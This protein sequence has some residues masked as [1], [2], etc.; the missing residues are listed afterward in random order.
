MPRSY[1][2]SLFLTEGQAGLDYEKLEH[3]GDALL[4][5][6]AV[7][8]AHELFPNFRQGSAAIMRDKLVS[9]STLAQIARQY[10]M[11][12]RIRCA[13]DAR[14]ALKKNEKVA[15]SVFEAY[16]AGVYY[17]YLQSTEE[18][19]P[20]SPTDS[21]NTFESSSRTSVDFIGGDKM[22]NPC[23]E[24]E[25]ISSDEEY[26]DAEIYSPTNT[27]SDD[28]ADF[29]EDDDFATSLNLLFGDSSSDDEVEKPENVLD[30][31]ARSSV[32][33][34]TSNQADRG[35]SNSFLPTDPSFRTTRTHPR[36]TRAQAYDYLYEW[37]E[38]V[39][40][41]IAHF[42]LAH[43]KVEDMRIKKEHGKSDEE[44]FIIPLHWKEEDIK[45][46]GGKAI[47][48]THFFELESPVYT[49]SSSNE[50][51]PPTQL[52]TIHCRV[53]DKEGT[54]WT[55][56]GTRTTKQAASNLAAWKIC[57]AMGLIKETD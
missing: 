9:N 24:G 44:P 57:V 22:N 12:D 15:A 31:K 14:H 8:L 17:S 10:G 1:S 18:S 5:A 42:A 29:D 43:L 52:W 13:Q 47:L 21:T 32:S 39:L 33:C 53:K 6:V 16:I 55:A 54:V 27:D 45:A 20:R 38:K 28:R 56:E 40:T 4:E 2:T 25:A 30:R 26:C 49:E 19:A 46:Q 7:T 34:E 37:L 23:D 3:V 41:S 36:R 48:N 51:R 35:I 11:H 50:G